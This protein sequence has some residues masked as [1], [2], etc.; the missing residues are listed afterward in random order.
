MLYTLYPLLL[1]ALFYPLLPL[2]LAY[3]LITGNHR[4]GIRQRL[5]LLP[6]LQPK[7]GLRIWLHAA[8]VGEVQVAALLI[9]ELRRRLPGVE[10]VLTTMTIHGRKF[11]EQQLDDVTCLLAPLD[12]PGIAGRGAALIDPDIYLCLETELWPSLLHNLRR[13]DV[14]ML[15]L[16]GRMSRRTVD[17]YRRYSGMFRP[18]L[19]NFARLCLI[20]DTDRERFRSVGIDGERLEVTGNIKYDRLPPDEA[21]EI[22]QRYRGILGL[23]EGTRVL[24]CGSTH[25][26]EEEMLFPVFSAMEKRCDFLWVVAPRHPRRLPDLRKLFAERGIEVNLLSSLL[27]GEK[28]R[29]RVVLVDTFGDLFNLYSVGT[30]IFCGGSLVDRRGHNIM[31]PALWGRYVFYGPSMDDFR[32]GRELLE[33]DGGGCTV[34]SGEDLLA[35]ILRFEEQPRRYAEVCEAAGA[36]ARAQQG[37]VARQIQVVMDVLEARN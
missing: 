32:D 11:A 37:A 29:C 18:V 1:V 6:G 16:N 34:R 20:S 33:R 25:T 24:V 5:A 35:R 3:V 28:R 36:T 21:G 31:E 4:E 15:L 26:G 7:R 13:K 8:S 17:T 22:R 19:A 9:G 10:I 27:A 14:P 23:S 30:Y 12:V 2:L